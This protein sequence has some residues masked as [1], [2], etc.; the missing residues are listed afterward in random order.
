MI[1]DIASRIPSLE[2]VIGVGETAP[3]GGVLFNTLLETYRKKEYPSDYLK[4]YRPDPNDIS[5]IGFT[6]GTTALPK[7]YIHTHNTELANIFNCMLFDAYSLLPK[8]CVNIA[9]PGFAWAYG[10]SSNLIAGVLSGVT[11]VTVDPLTPEN[12][13]ETFKEKGPPICTALRLSIAR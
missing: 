11:T 8:P 9:L 7:A 4:R 6:S 10:R 12:I 3:E 1:R 2:L 5:L 13:L